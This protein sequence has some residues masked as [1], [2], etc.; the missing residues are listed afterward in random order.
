MKRFTLY[1]VMVVLLFSAVT[2]HAQQGN[3]KAEMQQELKEIKQE[4]K[5]LEA[6]IADAKINYPE[7]VP[8]LEKELATTKKMLATIERLANPVQKI[9]IVQAKPIPAVTYQSPI[10]KVYLKQAVV[11][12]TEAM[13]K[14]KLLWYKGKK[15]NDSTLITT[16]GMVVQFSKKRNQVILQPEK[17]T[18]PFEK[19]IKE[20][21]KSNQRKDELIDKFDKMKNGFMYYRELEG[22]VARYDDIT[23]RFEGVLKNTVDVPEIPANIS[24]S[25]DL[26]NDPGEL[27]VKLNNYIED[28]KKEIERLISELGPVGDFPPP[29]AK[30]IG[31]CGTCDPELIKR[32]QKQDKAWFENFMG[33]EIKITQKILGL[34]KQKLSLGMDVNVNFD[35]FLGISERMNLK[36]KILQERYGNDMRYIF[37]VSQVVLGWERQ[38]QLLGCGDDDTNP[39]EN[40]ANSFKIYEEYFKQQIEVKDYNFILD[41]PFHLGVM[42]QKAI[43]GCAE[44]SEGFGKEFDQALKFNRFR[45]AINLDF[46][47][48]EMDDEGKTEFKATGILSEKEKIYTMMYRDSCT[49]KMAMY[50]AD[51]TKTSIRDVSIPMTVKSGVKQMKDED[52]N[53]VSF[54]YTG[55]PEYLLSFPEFKIN[56]CNS[57]VPDS[58]YFMPMFKEGEPVPINKTTS[59]KSYKTELLP[60]A[61]FMFINTE[62]ME[63]KSDEG[64][65]LAN[66]IMEGMFESQNMST[67]G[68]KLDKLKMQYEGKKKQDSYRKD[69]S[70]LAM[71]KKSVF[72]F[73]ANNKS[74]ILI[75]KFSETKRSL[76]ENKKLVKG[77]IEIR[78]VHDPEPPE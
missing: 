23:E 55:P 51:F 65:E 53:L 59:T 46:I 29:P 5:N 10:E 67:T 57:K 54:N 78:V 17:K 31:L 64:M 2:M 58:A 50:N 39:L 20:L 11:T 8:D 13:A 34:E 49:Y 14:D 60:I 26:S 3:M 66:K 40:L 68:S 72:L 71:D 18:D 27:L 25:A 75:N 37:T 16:K 35:E 41:I 56:F 45:M 19:M 73:S 4:I 6:E 12:P 7:D 32:E 9:P 77:L 38:K 48:E 36:N 15:I 1:L 22:A 76:G 24:Y 44:E 47:Y 30:E 43:L 61:N 62:D 74:T 70:K 52:G 21:E 63:D 69:I 33:K 28:T 42:R